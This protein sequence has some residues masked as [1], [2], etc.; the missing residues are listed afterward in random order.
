MDD[1]IQ[2]YVFNFIFKFLESS[3][4]VLGEEITVDD[5]IQS[6]KSFPKKFTNNK[7][8]LVISDTNTVQIVSRWHPSRNDLIFGR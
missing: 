3:P 4:R 7:Q 6:P 1:I 8:F 5:S 2:K